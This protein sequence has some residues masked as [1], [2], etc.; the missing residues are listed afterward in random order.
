VERKYGGLKKQVRL[1]SMCLTCEDSESHALCLSNNYNNILKLD[2]RIKL[3]AE[4]ETSCEKYYAYV[5]S[6]LATILF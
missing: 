3:K 1:L 4:K 5:N 2:E 6:E